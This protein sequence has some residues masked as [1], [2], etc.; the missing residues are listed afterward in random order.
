M[1]K[2]AILPDEYK[3][4]REKT[5][6]DLQELFQASDFVHMKKLD[7]AILR[8]I[9]KVVGCKS[10]SY[11]QEHYDSDNPEQSCWEDPHWAGL[12][13]MSE[14]EVRNCLFDVIRG[15]KPYLQNPERVFRFKTDD[16][17]FHIYIMLRD[18]NNRCDYWIQAK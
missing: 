10:V 8:R 9:F 2:K 1:L 11:V 17:I 16:G 7:C 13:R 14:R 3:V 6:K 4:Y 18:T 5:K 12:W 15:I